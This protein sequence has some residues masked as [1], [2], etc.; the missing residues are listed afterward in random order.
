MIPIAMPMSARFNAGASLTPSPVAATTWLQ[1]L[2]DHHFLG[3]ADARKQ[4]FGFVERDLQLRLGKPRELIS[5]DH[6]R[7]RGLHEADL[8]R[9]GKPGLRVIAGDHDDLDAGGAAGTDRVRHLGP[10]RVFEPHQPGECQAALPLL[11]RHVG[12]H[13][14]EREC[15]HAHAIVGKSRLR[16]AKTLAFLRRE[17]NC[18]SARFDR[19]AEWQYRFKR[20]FAIKYLP[21]RRC[22]Q[23][24]EPLAVAVERDFVAARIGG[25]RQQPRHVQQ[26]DFHR[27]AQELRAA[28]GNDLAQRVAVPR[29]FEQAPL[30]DSVVRR[31]LRGVVTVFGI[32]K[33]QPLYPHAVLRQGAGFVGADHGRRAERLDRRQMADQRVAFRHALR[34][35]RERQRHGGQQSFGHVGD[36]DADR[37]YEVL[38]ERQAQRQAERKKHAAEQH[39]DRRDQPA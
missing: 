17:R 16:R 31:D 14:A 13:R 22:M 24:G 19:R 10:H 25:T 35:H 20:A 39:G 27:V 34:A 38:P 4:Y 12:G 8:A 33:V 11:A 1:R 26:S 3:G 30:L 23:C 32:G 21:V 9:N 5:G 28:A 15:E 18:A 7:P 6:A 37:E 29:D 2:D 36:D